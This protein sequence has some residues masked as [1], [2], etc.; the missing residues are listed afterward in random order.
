[1]PAAYAPEETRAAAPTRG[2]VQA[3]PQRRVNRLPLVHRLDAVNPALPSD[4]RRNAS[5]AV[6]LGEHARATAP[7]VSYYAA[8]APPCPPGQPQLGYAPRRAN[9]GY[10]PR[11]AWQDGAEIALVGPRWLPRS[12]LHPSQRFPEPEH[13]H[14]NTA[15]DARDARDPG[16]LDAWAPSD[17]IYSPA[18]EDTD[19]AYD[20]GDPRP[21]LRA[22]L[23]SAL[24]T[25][26]GRVLLADLRAQARAGFGVRFG[27]RYVL[28]R[29]GIHQFVVVLY[30]LQALLWVL[31]TL[32][33]MGLVGAE[34]GAE[35]V[36]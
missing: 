36:V 15:H 11:P 32:G 2:P 13:G 19:P 1:M 21:S 16:D 34:F 24:I 14:I 26:A 35:C 6:G 20:T 29:A 27:L 5:P 7:A 10:A 8:P 31:G 17:T 3:Q 4:S 9:V 18:Y 22:R 33:G 30:A 12:L 23:H 28:L 25:P